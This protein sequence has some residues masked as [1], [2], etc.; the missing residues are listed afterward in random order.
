[1]PLKLLW[2]KG[3]GSAEN[4]FAPPKKHLPRRRISSRHL[5]DI[6]LM[7]I[8]PPK[9]VTPAGLQSMKLRDHPLMC[10]VD[11]RAWPPTWLWRGGSE[12]TRPTGEVGLLKDV[13]LSDIDPPTRCFL[14]MQ[15]MGAEYIGCL[16]F[17]N[18]G[19]C[20]EIYEVLGEHR[21]NSI[22]EIGNVDISYPLNGAG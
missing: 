5:D 18:S 11:M 20:R 12:D 1:M 16:S 19:F 14:V 9:L 7:I 3:V 2:L 10:S 21:G 15:H 6:Y 17:E 8:F 13:I 22:D 4:S